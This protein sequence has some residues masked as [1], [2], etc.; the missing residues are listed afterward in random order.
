MPINGVMFGQPLSRIDGVSMNDVSS[1]REVPAGYVPYELPTLTLQRPIRLAT[2]FLVLMVLLQVM[3]P[4]YLAVYLLAVVGSSMLRFEPLVHVPAQILVVGASFVV[5]SSLWRVRDAAPV[6]RVSVLI[7]IKTVAFAAASVL[8]TLFWSF[9]RI[10][11]S[12]L[13]T[14]LFVEIVDFAHV[15]LT[16]AVVLGIWIKQKRRLAVFAPTSS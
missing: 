10:D 15:A 5:W 3:L 14:L 13:S 1:G 6:R 9:E 4:R 8:S 2:T 12:L 11:V 16:I 7:V